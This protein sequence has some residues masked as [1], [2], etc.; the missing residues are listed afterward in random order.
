[1]IYQGIKLYDW[2]RAVTDIVCKPKAHGITVVKSR[3]Q[4][5]K[6]VLLE[7]ILLFYAINYKGVSAA[8]SPTLNQSRKL[9]KDII[10]A[11][12]GT[13]IIKKKNESLLEIT[14]TNGSQ[15]FF[16]SAE[17]KDAL[18]GYTLKNGILCIDEASFISDDI[19][20][21]VMPWT[22]V[23][24]VPILMLSTPKFKVGFFYRYFSMGLD[25]DNK[26]IVSVDW[27][28]FDTSAL[29]SAEQLEE[30]R[31]IMPLAQFKS[32]YLG[33]F[34][35]EG[36]SVFV[37]YKNC[38]GYDGSTDY[39]KL[40]VG[41]DWGVGGNNDDTVLTAIDEYGNERFMFY[42]NNLS[43][44]EQIDVIADFCLAHKNEIV[45]AVPE[46]NS[47][48]TPMTD[49]LKARLPWLNIEGH[50]TSNTSKN[51][52]IKALQVAF[53]QQKIRLLDDAK[54]S[55]ELSIYSLEFNPKTRTVTFNAPQGMHDDICISL[56]LAW[57][58]YQNGTALGFYAVSGMGKNKNKKRKRYSGQ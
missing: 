31:R 37:G 44:T 32:E 25:P 35:E 12:A 50:N 22:Q 2:Q 16:K 48:G 9:F 52:I 3:R 21:L 51:D 58:A 6:S 49:L 14:L 47:I 36:D 5:G 19:L 34:L 40:F 55:L 33:E 18:R 29:L 57:K 56:A 54:Q 17:Q 1:M 45:Q 13:G 7:N 42:F 39:S 28:T 10:D 43:T 53:E 46:L 41:I 26:K 8:I 38:I 27:S 24:K 15:I 20:E 23:H 11:I 30:Y 4:C